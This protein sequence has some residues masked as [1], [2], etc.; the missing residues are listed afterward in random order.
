MKRK[1]LK[2]AVQG[3]TRNTEIRKK[4]Q[5]KVILHAAQKIKWRREGWVII[6]TI[7]GRIQQRYGTHREDQEDQ[8]DQQQDR[9]NDMKKKNNYNKCGSEE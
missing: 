2:I 9:L 3:H 6:V 4:A 7:D 5:I 8:A 1:I